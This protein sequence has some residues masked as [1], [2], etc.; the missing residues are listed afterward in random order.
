MSLH[1]KL[2]VDRDY[3]HISLV[4]KEGNKR[5]IDRSKPSSVEIEV[6]RWRKANQI[7]N[8]FVQNVQYGE[9]D[10]RKYE[11][12]TKALKRQA[13]WHMKDRLQVDMPEKADLPQFFHSAIPALTDLEWADEN[14]PDIVA[15]LAEIT[16]K[17]AAN[18]TAWGSVKE[19][20]EPEEQA[21]E[22]AEEDVTDN[23]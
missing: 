3:D 6:G 17:E 4:D 1:I 23:L 5:P 12:D 7:H 21:E 11:V 20:E 2:Y 19:E 15:K 10:C 16:D 8:W 9:D 14:L 18:A 13:Y 22:V